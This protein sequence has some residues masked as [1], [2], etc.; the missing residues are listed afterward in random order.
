LRNNPF[1]IL[2]FIAYCFISCEQQI[3]T[4]SSPYLRSTST[5]GFDEILVVTDKGKHDF[6]LRDSIRAVLSA[7][8][9]VLPQPEP[10]F[11]VLHIG[12]NDFD[13]IFKRYRTVLFFAD[14]SKNVPV[15]RFIKKTLGD[16]YLAKALQ[17]ENFTYALKKN[18]WAEPQLL[19]FIFGK[20]QQMLFENWR[21]SSAKI[22]ATISKNEQQKY[23][24]NLYLSGVNHKLTEKLRNEY[25]IKIKIPKE[26]EL[27]I[28]DDNF[29]WIRKVTPESSNNIMIGFKEINENQ[30]RSELKNL[31]TWRNEMGAK[32]ITNDHE[33]AFMKSDT[34]LPFQT[35]RKKL[36]ATACFEARGLWRMENDFMGGP[37]LSYLIEDQINQRRIF[38]DG[39]VFSPGEMKKPEVRRLEALFSGFEVVN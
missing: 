13:K 23:L 34:I 29:I 2:L 10:I 9:E 5:G 11:K 37:F 20:N 21:T 27:A 25:K 39:F 8:Y 31:I 19:V 18:V 16:E 7:F 38:I 22:S 6:E 15:T 30:N 14:L 4:D 24:N 26:Y 1:I 35:T 36:G 32:Y 12:F 17:D 28:E 3:S 33:G